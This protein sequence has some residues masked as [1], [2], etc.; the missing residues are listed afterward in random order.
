VFLVINYKI[1][2]QFLIDVD[3]SDDEIVV[4]QINDETALQIEQRVYEV[5]EQEVQLDEVDV[6]DVDDDDDDE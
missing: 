2:F 6:D 1:H 3:E 5:D 4:V